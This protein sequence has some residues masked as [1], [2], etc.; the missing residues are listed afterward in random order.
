MDLERNPQFAVARQTLNLFNKAMSATPSSFSQIQTVHSRRV[1][2]RRTGLGACAGA[3]GTA[4]L[5][6]QPLFGAERKASKQKVII[7]SGMYGWGQYYR[8][9]KKNIADH[10]DETFAA[11]RDCGYEFAE[12]FLDVKTPENNGKLA[13]Q[14][15]A[16]GLKP[17]CLYTNAALHEKDKADE[18]VDQL[19]KA[20]KICRQAGFTVID[21][22]PT[23]QKK[24]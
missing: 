4:G 23:R 6:T 20:A 7:G 16:K 5:L 2:L 15:K 21:C 3:L 12:G 1:F 18:T 17:L 8:R 11:I 9:D 10:M 13:D 19:M 24:N 22:N 14:M